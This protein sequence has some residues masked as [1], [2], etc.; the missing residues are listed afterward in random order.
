M[1]STFFDNCECF[2][3]WILEFLEQLLDSI[4][5]IS[6]SISY[7]SG[8]KPIM[9]LF[10]VVLE[11]EFYDFIMAKSGCEVKRSPLVIV[12]W[13]QISSLF[14]LFLQTSNIFVLNIWHKTQRQINR[15]FRRQSTKQITVLLIKYWFL[16]CFFHF[17]LLLSAFGF[18]I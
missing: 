17:F 12:S 4:L 1:P 3:F 10:N 11:E 18:K 8:S 14:K 13:I 7:G 2:L 6:N 15:T 5:L 16:K 9:F